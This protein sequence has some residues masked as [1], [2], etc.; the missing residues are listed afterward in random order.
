MQACTHTWHP[1]PSSPYTHNTVT[2]IPVFTGQLT[3]FT[4]HIWCICTLLHLSKRHLWKETKAVQKG[5]ATHYKQNTHPVTCN[6]SKQLWQHIKTCQTHIRLIKTFYFYFYKLPAQLVAELEYSNKTT[7]FS[8]QIKPAKAA[9]NK[10]LPSF[11]LSRNHE[12]VWPS[13]KVL[14]WLSRWMVKSTLALVSHCKWWFM[15]IV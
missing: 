4:D 3:Y 12:P 13:G 6:T 8:Q 5:T 15:D 9:A 7:L 2:H 1:P 11:P 14:A 10:K